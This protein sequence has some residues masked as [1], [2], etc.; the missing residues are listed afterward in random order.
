VSVVR[1]GRHV[2]DGVFLGEVEASFIRGLI[3]G[4]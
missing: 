4:Y 1:K 3:A 2:L